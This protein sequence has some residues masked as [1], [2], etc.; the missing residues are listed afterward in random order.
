MLQSREERTVRHDLATE[1]QQQ[2][3]TVNTYCT[4][5]IHFPLDG[6]LGCF[7]V[8]AIVESAAA[9]KKAIMAYSCGSQS[10][11]SRPAALTSPEYL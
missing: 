1:Q 4:F 6:R 2:Y 9:F 7:H 5:F 11:G 8:L 3:P 10:E